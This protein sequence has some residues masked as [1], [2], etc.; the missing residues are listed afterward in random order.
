MSCAE[1][2]IYSYHL[3]T[4]TCSDSPTRFGSPFLVTCAPVVRGA[5]QDEGALLAP[6]PPLL[7]A[8]CWPPPSTP[9]FGA[10]PGWHRC[11]RIV[12]LRVAQASQP[13]RTISDL[14]LEVF[15][16]LLFVC[17][18]VLV[19][20]NTQ[21]NRRPASPSRPTPTTIFIYFP[22]LC[23][24]ANGNACFAGLE[25]IHQGGEGQ[26]ATRHDRSQVCSRD[27]APEE[28][29]L[30]HCPPPPPFLLRKKLELCPAPQRLRM[31]ATATGKVPVDC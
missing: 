20:V 10:A 25:E 8:H 1:S 19:S 29:A 6:L 18:R 15:G 26:Q 2:I 5:T 24:A 31:G 21:V 4:S 27:R 12:V 16:S 14:T 3:W 13:M 11:S 17:A 9:S 7:P 30:I 22:K 23:P 28:G